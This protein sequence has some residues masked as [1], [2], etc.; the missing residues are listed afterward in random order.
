MTRAPRARDDDTPD[1]EDAAAGELGDD[2]DDD[3]DNDLDDEDDEDDDLGEEEDDDDG[4]AAARGRG[5][6]ATLPMAAS[7]QAAL[8]ARFAILIALPVAFW[9]AGS[10]A[11]GVIAFLVLAGVM[12]GTLAPEGASP[13]A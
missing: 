10:F 1:D 5:A 2:L 3:L 8:I 11:V 9:I 4:T 12:A 13:A 7:G 6:G